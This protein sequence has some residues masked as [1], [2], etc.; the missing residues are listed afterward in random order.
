[1]NLS[2]SLK[3]FATALPERISR[4]RQ[5]RFQEWR[6][7]REW[8]PIMKETADKPRR[9]ILKL[10]VSEDNIDHL[11]RSSCEAIFAERERAYQQSYRPI[12]PLDEL[13]ARYGDM[14]N[15]KLYAMSRDVEGRWLELHE[16]ETGIKRPL[17]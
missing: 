3:K 6:S 8:I 4:L 10:D 1:M 7:E 17:D 13:S 16:R 12:P 11:E 15:R 14:A 9:L 5:G 2:G